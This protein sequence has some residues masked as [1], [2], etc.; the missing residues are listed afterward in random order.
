ME[1]VL[2]WIDEG[3]AL[4]RE[5]LGDLEA[6]SLLPGWSRRHVAAHLSL[7]A[8]ALGNLVEWARTG[9]ERPMYP[10]REARDA[11]I[12]AGTS[13]SA[14]ELRSWFEAATTGL[15]A[16]MATLTDAQWQAE[17]R[18]SRGEP[19]PATRIPWMRSREVMIHA[20]DLGTGLTFADLPTDFL[21]ALCEDIRTERGDVPKVNGPLP[22]IAAY[23]TGRPYT[24]VTGPEGNAAHPLAPWL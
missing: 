15:S 10:S 2:G 7:N 13:R 6:P 11:D 4:C 24:N 16:S 21:E 9:E 14:D 1:R 20:V 12:E 3:T 23:L 17:V 8:E 18:T 19:I 22:E 5:A